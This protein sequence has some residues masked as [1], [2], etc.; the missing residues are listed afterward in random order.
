MVLDIL[1]D[2]DWGSLSDEKDIFQRLCGIDLLI[3]KL[4]DSNFVGV[5]FNKI[6]DLILE[7]AGDQFEVYQAKNHVEGQPICSFAE[8]TRKKKAS[9]L[10]DLLPNANLSILDKLIRSSKKIEDANP[11]INNVKKIVFLT[12]HVIDKTLSRLTM[13]NE[14]KYRSDEEREK[15]EGAIKEI[16]SQFQNARREGKSKYDINMNLIRKFRFISHHPGINDLKN[17]ILQELLTIYCEIKGSTN[18][19]ITQIK[20]IIPRLRIKVE[21][22]SASDTMPG[23]F[24]GKAEIFD[25]I[26]AEFSKPNQN[27]DEIRHH[28]LEYK[29]GQAKFNETFREEAK[30]YLYEKKKIECTF[31]TTEVRDEMQRIYDA[32]RSQCMGVKNEFLGKIAPIELHPKYEEKIN[33][34]VGISKDSPLFRSYL[35]KYAYGCF[36]YQVDDCS[37]T[38]SVIN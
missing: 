25:W 30:D 12:N 27:S 21:D 3:Q 17:R 38:W 34:I 24:V 5:Y 22:A 29:I 9:T 8:I 36:Y 28:S 23:S 6:D 26:Q 10:D 35:R 37:L 11:S 20:S 1:P 13:H 15:I 31:S 7:Y 16:H 4:R 19:N 33:E 18:V 32:I 2:E 14:A